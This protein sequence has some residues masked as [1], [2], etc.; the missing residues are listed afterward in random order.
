MVARLSEA[1]GVYPQRIREV[2]AKTGNQTDEIV[3]GQILSP[4]EAS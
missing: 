4:Q 2:L 3:G 1:L